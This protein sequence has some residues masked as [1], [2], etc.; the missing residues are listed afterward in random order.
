MKVPSPKP[1]QL[2]ITMLLTVF[3][4]ANNLTVSQTTDNR[5][6]SI[7]A[8][9]KTTKIST[10]ATMIEPRSTIMVVKHNQ[11]QRGELVRAIVHRILDL[12]VSPL[13]ILNLS[14]HKCSIIPTHVNKSKKRPSLIPLL[15]PHRHQVSLLSSSSSTRGRRQLILCSTDSKTNTKR[16]QQPR[17]LMVRKEVLTISNNSITI[18]HKVATSL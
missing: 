12:Q 5:C 17:N 1:N 15:H 7:R 8:P 18:Q 9:K 14:S 13:A 4:H 16:Y 2:Q 10:T 6:I 3:C 11:R